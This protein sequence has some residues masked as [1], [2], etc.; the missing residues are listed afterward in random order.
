V[1]A[2]ATLKSPPISPGRH[3][4]PPG[5]VVYMQRARILD[6]TVRVVAERGYA[7]A[8]MQAINQALGVTK[9]T[10][11]GLYP[12]RTDVAVATMGHGLSFGVARICAAFDAAGTPGEKVQ[13][14]IDALLDL[15]VADVEWA[16]FVLLEA[17]AAG[18]PA[19]ERRDELLA[20]IYARFTALTPKGHRAT[21]PRWVVDAA[22]GVLRPSLLA[23][24]VTRRPWL[25]HELALLIGATC[26]LPA[27]QRRERAPRRR[28]ERARL[29]DRVNQAFVAVDGEDGV[30]DVH[31][32]LDE[33]L[34][35][36]HGPAL[37]QIVRCLVA[38]KDDVDF[39][40]DGMKATADAALATAWIFGTPLANPGARPYSLNARRLQA[41][42]VVRANPGC[43][44][45]F[46]AFG[47]GEPLVA[48]RR[49]LAELRDFGL[50]RWDRKL[51]GF[52]L[53]PDGLA[54]LEG[55][56]AA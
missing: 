5:A 21:A 27:P 34:Q 39:R 35:H 14:A 2:A 51:R 31:A 22:I 18:T 19:W 45:E 47:L 13:A 38:R 44:D 8:T 40:F 29:V 42:E 53:T 4:F 10:L 9:S 16:R 43:N 7:L 12:S 55:R 41:L 25:H 6:G 23:G 26:G 24:K 11:Y 1:P 54:A 36:A 49:A 37:W 48:A 30:A 46:V 3:G 32:V 56:A 15:V 33:A 28:V 50:V 20:P 52:A 17:N